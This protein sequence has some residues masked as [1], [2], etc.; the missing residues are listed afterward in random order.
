MGLLRADAQCRPEHRV[1]VDHILF[2]G[3]KPC[4]PSV[5]VGEEIPQKQETDFTALRRS[6]FLRTRVTAI[7]ACKADLG[8]ALTDSKLKAPIQCAIYFCNLWDDC[9][10][11]S[12]H[13]LAVN[14]NTLR[15]HRFLAIA[16]KQ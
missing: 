5:H 2:A 9:R 11:L 6:L 16:V 3:G 8:M 7:H 1:C 4:Y 12:V 15:R 13:L 14:R 10:H